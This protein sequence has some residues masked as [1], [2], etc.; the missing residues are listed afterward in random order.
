LSILFQQQTSV[1]TFIELDHYELFK[2]AGLKAFERAQQEEAAAFTG[3]C[4]L[5]ADLTGYIPSWL[6]DSFL[7]SVT[8]WYCGV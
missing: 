8:T 6:I 2:G 4:V 1:E 5:A 3:L 7:T